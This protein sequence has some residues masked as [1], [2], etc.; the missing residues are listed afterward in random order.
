MICPRPKQR[1]GNRELSEMCILCM[2]VGFILVVIICAALEEEEE[3]EEEE[4]Y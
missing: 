3:E 1:Q 2:I 4:D